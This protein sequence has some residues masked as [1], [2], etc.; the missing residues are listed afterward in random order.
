MAKTRQSFVESEPTHLVETVSLLLKSR[1]NRPLTPAQR[2]FNRLTTQVEE[3]QN[4]IREGNVAA[5]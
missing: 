1:P 5:G 3:L 2:T 4:P